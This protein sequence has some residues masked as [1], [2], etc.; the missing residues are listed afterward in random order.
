MT[1]PSVARAQICWLA[2]SLDTDFLSGSENRTLAD[3]SHELV[4]LYAVQ[5]KTGSVDIQC[6]MLFPSISFGL[7]A[8]HSTHVYI[9]WQHF[10]PRSTQPFSSWD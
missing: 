7:Y 4:A 3:F 5:V 1:I 9:C 2:M 10:D 6:Q 8:I